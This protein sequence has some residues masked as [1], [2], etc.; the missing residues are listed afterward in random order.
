MKLNKEE[1]GQRRRIDFLPSGSDPESNRAFVQLLLM[2]LVL[3]VL[4]PGK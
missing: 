4:F 2:G 3:L 1:K